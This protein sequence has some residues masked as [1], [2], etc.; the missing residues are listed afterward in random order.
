M[1]F[2]A[3]IVADK[4]EEFAREAVAARQMEVANI[5][6]HAAAQIDLT[7]SQL[8]QCW[9]GPM[10]GQIARQET[11][12]EILASFAPAAIVETGTFR[13]ITTI[14]LAHIFAGPIYTC[15][16]SPRLFVQSAIK[17]RSYPTVVIR[18]SDSRAFLRH[19]CSEVVPGT[20]AVFYLDAHWGADLPLAEEIDIILARPGSSVIVIDDFAVDH[21]P[22]Y[23]FDD[24]GPGKRL[25]LSYIAPFKTRLSASMWP[26]TPSAKE[27]GARR[28]MCVLASDARAANVLQRI[29]GLVPAN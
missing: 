24:Y 5:L 1:S 19:I 28:G 20:P 8:Q 3:S 21:D 25:D 29:P 7:D 22:G 9:G 4:C 27:T 26:A 13:A 6:I 17:L 16:A 15:E 2:K 23:G 10:N 18:Q 14:W 12:R 11:F